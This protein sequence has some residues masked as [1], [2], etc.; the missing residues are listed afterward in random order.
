MLLLHTLQLLPLLLML[1]WAAVEDLRTRRIRNWLTFSL[2]CTGIA[3]GLTGAGGG[4]GSIGSSLAGAGVGFFL[5]LLLFAIGA[6]GG[7]DVKLLAGVG[8][9]I[10]PMPVFQ[11]F[12]AAAIVGMVIVLGQAAAQGRLRILSRNSAVLA[13]NLVHLGDVGVEHAAA[14]GRSC[15]SVEKP[16]PYAVPVLLAVSSLLAAGWIG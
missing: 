14:T 15:R 9:W 16:L 7:G 3:H 6:M 11:V 13:V 1:A 12:C 2:L 10:G 4:A 5:P 8:A